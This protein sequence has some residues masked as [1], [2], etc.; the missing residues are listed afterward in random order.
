MRFGIWR[1]TPVAFALATAF[2]LCLGSVQQVQADGYHL[3][4]TI[5]RTVD[6]Y[7]F[8]TGGPYYAPPIPYGHYA[9]DPL[10][11]IAGCVNCKLH[12]LLGGGPC[13][14][15]K[16]HGGDGLGL[17]ACGACGGKG[18][19]LCSTGG[20]FGKHHG[21]SVVADPVGTAFV[22]HHGAV[23]A[24]AQAPAP[25]LASSQAP[26]GISGCGIFAGHRHKGHGKNGNPC[27]L[28]HGKGCGP[29][30]GDGFADGCGSPGCGLCGGL[31][32]GC[33]FCGGKGC[34][35]C[36]GGLGGKVHGKLASILHLGPKVEYFVGPGGPVPITPGYVPYIVSTRSPRD[37]FSFAPMNPDAR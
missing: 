37:Y 3:T 15:H 8:T 32:H 1:G 5:P 21:E 22:G 29:C 13:L 36:L 6:A 12:G 16:G 33:S 2:T 30:G 14:L 34:G 26:C 18:C 19:G 17:G 20:H 7:D 35:N 27:G 9:K 31:G 11:G 28:C 10:G 24:T 23:A 25:A 4:D